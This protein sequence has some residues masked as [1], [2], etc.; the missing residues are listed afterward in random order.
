M[1]VGQSSR[2]VW[3]VATILVVGFSVSVPAQSRLTKSP[4]AADTRVI[5]A[6]NPALIASLSRLYA[7]SPAWRQAVDEL[8]A[9]CS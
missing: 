7:G 2:F 4:P 5:Q 6:H 9:T 1:N 3:S 8:A